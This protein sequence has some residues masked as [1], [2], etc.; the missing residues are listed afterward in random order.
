MRSDPFYNRRLFNDRIPPT[1]VGG[2]VQILST[3]SVF[4]TTSRTAEL[5]RVIQLKIFRQ[6]VKGGCKAAVV[7]RI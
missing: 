1:A 2:C 6:R 5:S 4:V 3:A 7:E